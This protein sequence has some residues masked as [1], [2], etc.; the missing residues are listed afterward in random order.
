MK[1]HYIMVYGKKSFAM[2]AT[3]FQIIEINIFPIA[4][5]KLFIYTDAQNNSVTVLSI[6]KN[7]QSTF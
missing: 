1:C 2:H 7:C 5:F 6:K 3:L 4:S